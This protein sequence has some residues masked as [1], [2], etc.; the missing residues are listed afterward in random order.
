MAISIISGIAI[1]VLIVAMAAACVYF[2]KKSSK[3]ML[4]VTA[5][6]AVVLLAAMA[7]VPMSFHTVE[8]GE[9]VVVKH[10]G[11]AKYVRNAGTYFDLWITNKCEKYDAKKHLY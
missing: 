8:T 5:I 10:L 7:I 6:A 9:V 11:E 3:T 1:V 4:T 2:Y